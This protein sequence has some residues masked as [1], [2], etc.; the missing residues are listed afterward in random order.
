M[1]QLRSC[2]IALAVALTA[3]SCGAGQRPSGLAAILPGSVSGQLSPGLR[4]FVEVLPE[5]IDAFGYLDLGQ[6]VDELVDTGGLTHDILVDLREM[7]QRRWGVDLHQLQGAGFTAA[8]EEFVFFAMLG[9]NVTL[10]LPPGAAMAKLGAYTA[11]GNPAAIAALQASAQKGKLIA[12]DPTW[13]RSALGYAGGATALVAFR[14]RE[15]P[16]MP[17]AP[18]KKDF[19]GRYAT[20]TAKAD[21]LALHLLAEPG[22]VAEMRAPIEAALGEA[23]AMIAAPVLGQH[24]RPEEVLAKLAI[25]HYG[26]AVLGG[27][28]SSTTGDELHYTLPWRVPELPA[29]TAAPALAERLVLH[30]EWAVMQ[31]HLGRP[32]VQL[33]VATTDLIGAA[34]DRAKVTDTLVGLASSALDFP[35]IDPSTATVSVGGMAGAVSLHGAAPGVSRR[36]F[37]AGH[38]ELLAAGTPWGLA[39]TVGNM[40]DA[41]TGALGQAA[42][43]MPLASSSRFAARRDLYLRGMI[44][45]ERMP[46]MAKLMLGRIPVRSMEFGMSAT[47]F[48]ADVLA[49]SGQAAAVVQLTEVAKE[50][51]AAKLDLGY[52]KRQQSP[53]EVEVLAILQH[54]QLMA[55]KQ[56]LTPKVDGDRLT[57]SYS[58]PEV[59]MRATAIVYGVGVITGLSIPAFM[60]YVKH[61]S[62]PPASIAQ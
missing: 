18:K 37:S 26:G 29:M 25:E 23:R 58:W 19:P 20:A 31:V 60:S 14:D 21:G 8:N 44:D 17:S 1:M 15:D 48:E 16:S 50:A 38:G 10:S 39:V 33:L 54:H 34:L 24:S 40:G 27:L 30:D 46:T 35:R 2:A 28:Q 51:L 57:F 13:L 4:S 42:Q 56:F 49:T 41:L 47:T 12:S 7:A 55:A 59:S 62:A 11:L 52:A 3:T 32:L 43:P 5:E 61:P 9:D 53:A 36:A 22:K 6:P 45:L